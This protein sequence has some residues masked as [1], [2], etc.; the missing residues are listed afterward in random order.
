MPNW[1]SN[2]L[3]INGSTNDIY[4]FK[5]KANG[6]VQ[7]YH[8]YSAQDAKWPVH[9]DVRLKAMQET[10]PEPGYP[11]VFSFHA[12]FPV[13]SEVR[14]L[15]YD[16][17]R[18]REMAEYLGLANTDVRGGYDWEYANW[19]VKWGASEATLQDDG[20]SFLEYTFDTPWGPP[21]SFITKIAEDWSTLS[22]GLEYGD[23]G[24]GNSGEVEF[25]RGK[26]V[27]YEEREEEY[28]DWDE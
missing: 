10:L 4:K 12:L 20:D 6:P 22:F 21:I 15:P 24:T 5:L 25:S 8:D 11:S 23:G 13:P 19:G 18:A 17:V 9:D 7:S 16:S 28:G 14:R 26:M 3:S 27:S 2:R 1:C